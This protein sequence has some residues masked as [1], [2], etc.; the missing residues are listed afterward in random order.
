[1]PASGG[2]VDVHEKG[3]DSPSGRPKTDQCDYIPAV[4]QPSVSQNSVG[5]RL[6]VFRVD[7]DPLI[8]CRELGV[9]IVDAGFGGR[10]F[11]RRSC[12]PLPYAKVLED[13]FPTG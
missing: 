6:G 8:R 5:G 2:G 12:F 3:V 13:F 7:I 11:G 4:V 9:G 1:V 10:G